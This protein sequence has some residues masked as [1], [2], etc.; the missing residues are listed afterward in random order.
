MLVCCHDGWLSCWLI[1][2]MYGCHDGW[3]SRWLAVMMVGCHDGW[4]HVG[5]LSLW[6]V[7]M[8]DGCHVGWLVVIMVGHR[9]M[10]MVMVGQGMVVVAVKC[11]HYL[12]C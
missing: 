5:W 11:Y 4:C 1:V 10:W 8:M 9:F 12:L 6:L 3:L 7:V 2:M